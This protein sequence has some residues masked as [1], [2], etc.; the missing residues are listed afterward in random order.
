MVEDRENPGCQHLDN[1]D[2]NPVGGGFP[3]E[4]PAAI[5]RRQGESSEGIVLQFQG[6]G[7]V[8]SQER[9]E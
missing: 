8:E 2:Q 3:Q 6:E 9:G 1:G 5:A 4:Y 7:A